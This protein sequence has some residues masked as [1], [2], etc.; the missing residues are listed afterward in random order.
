ME[1]VTQCLLVSNDA[2]RESRGEGS[3]DDQN[4]HNG[5]EEWESESGNAD[6]DMTTI[7]LNHYVYRADARAGI[8]GYTTS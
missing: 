3:D 2:T 8:I 1:T 7:L 4:V 5:K 6:D